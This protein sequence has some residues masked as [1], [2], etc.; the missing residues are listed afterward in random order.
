MTHQR[1]A[2]RFVRLTACLLLCLLTLAGCTSP[3][4]QPPAQTAGQTEAPVAPA[5]EPSTLPAVTEPLTDAATEPITDPETTPETEPPAPIDGAALDMDHLARLTDDKLV[6]RTYRCAVTRAEDPGEGLV[7]RLGA[8][9]VGSPGHT[10]PYVIFN[11]GQAVEALGGSLPAAGERPFLVLKVKADKLWS[12]TARVMPGTTPREAEN[13]PA[14]VPAHIRETDEWQYLVFDLSSFGKEVAAFKLVFEIYA[15]SNDDALL[16]SEMRFCTAEEAAPLLADIN[17]YPLLRAG[18]GQKLKVLQFN[19]QTEN[20]TTVPF[21]LRADMLRTL[22]DR[23]QPDVVGM[24]EVT[25]A[26]RAWLDTYAFNQSYRGVGG[27]RAPGDESCPIYYRADKFELLD[28]GTFWLSSTPDVPGSKV[29][30]ANLPR[31]ATWVKLKDLTTGF[32][33][34]HVNV[35]LDHNGNN[36]SGV[37][38]DVRKAQTK[39]LLSIAETMKDYPMILTGDFNQMRYTSAGTAYGF[40]NYITGESRFTNLSGVKTTGWFSDA[41]YQAPDTMDEQ[42]SATM[43]KY[44][45]QSSS[46]YQPDRL[47]IDYMFY[48]PAQLDPLVYRTFLWER[49]GIYLSDHLP[50]YGE[51]AI[52]GN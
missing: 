25:P 18:D 29:E 49:N 30:N 34:V 44:Y 50:L 33:F 6:S 14:S 10:T 27:Q 3:A 31:I 23:L 13:Q 46:S 9:S 39:V 37:A 32:T 40:Y 28:T 16:V 11:Y 45:D 5:T 51:F 8:D 4:P 20:G 47:P 21:P 38:K 42:H 26:W 7:L 41:R 52:K 12:Y 19:I 22:L 36:E 48:S 24:E 35:H 2:R 15:G 17:T 43:V 1:H